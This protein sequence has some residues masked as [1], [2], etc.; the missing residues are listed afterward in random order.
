MAVAK[1]LELQLQ[2]QYFQWIFKIDFLYNW[3]VW[4]PCS[5]RD[6]QES[7]PAHTSK[8]SILQCSTFFMVHLSHWHMTTGKTITLIRWTFVG[9]VMSLLFSMLSRFIITFLP[10]SKCLLISWLKSPSA[11]ILKPKKIKSLTVFIV[12]SCICHKVMGLD[13]MILVFWML[14]FKPDFSLSSFTFIKRLTSLS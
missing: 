5:P 4:S 7:S 14:S 8:A 1:G 2:H 10:K 3:L 9:K 11:V 6:S 13:A 12:S